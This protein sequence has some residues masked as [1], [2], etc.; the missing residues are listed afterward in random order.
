MSESHR[1]HPPSVRIPSWL[2]LTAA[3]SSLTLVAGCASFGLPGTD[4]WD[5]SFLKGN[6]PEEFQTEHSAPL[7]TQSWAEDELP[8]RRIRPGDVAVGMSLQEVRSHWGSPREV[9][10]AGE[11]R[12]G[13]QRWIFPM[14]ADP[15]ISAARVIY[16]E[17]GR[18]IGWE[19][20]HP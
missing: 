20:V 1:L 3:S 10:F 15:R 6:G 4:S 11:S 12:S 13:N 17:R 16:F 8:V 9:E 19:T 18:V 7:R 14:G 5:A 2:L